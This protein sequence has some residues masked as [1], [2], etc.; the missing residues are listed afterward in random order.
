MEK[1]IRF[2]LA[3]ASGR[4]KQEAEERWTDLEETGGELLQ[5]LAELVSDFR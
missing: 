2:C 1:Q 5:L 3:T 4:R